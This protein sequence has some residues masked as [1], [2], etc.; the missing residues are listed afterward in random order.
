MLCGMDEGQQEKMGTKA[1]Q[2][3]HPGVDVN[4][5]LRRGSRDAERHQ[6][7][8]CHVSYDFYVSK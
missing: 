7:M 4:L 1:V 6:E 2:R 5:G 3:F 8:R